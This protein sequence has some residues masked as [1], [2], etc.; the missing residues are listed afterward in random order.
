MFRFE[1]WAVGQKTKD[2]I[3][4]YDNNSKTFVYT[5]MERLTDSQNGRM[6]DEINGI[7]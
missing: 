4:I 2:F 3:F 7:D 1:E 6:N 5:E